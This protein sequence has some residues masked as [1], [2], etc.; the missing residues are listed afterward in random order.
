MSAYDLKLS[1]LQLQKDIRKRTRT[2][3][4]RTSYLYN[5]FHIPAFGEEN[6]S[7]HMAEVTKEIQKGQES[8]FQTDTNHMKTNIISMIDKIYPEVAMAIK[9]SARMKKTVTHG[10]A[11]DITGMLLCP[12]NWNW[13]DDDIKNK[14]CTQPKSCSEKAWP[15]FLYPKE[16]E[17]DHNDLI[18]V[19]LFKGELLVL[20]KNIFLRPPPSP[21]PGVHH[22]PSLLS[23]RNATLGWLI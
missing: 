20:L 18:S 15:R 14:L 17:P 23:P 9:L 10:F 1:I 22:P 16:S 13:E 2:L 21:Q 19:E 6:N 7:T 11:N 4:A 8:A 3:L 5:I 12:V